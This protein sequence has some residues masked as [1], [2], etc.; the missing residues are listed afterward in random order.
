MIEIP[1]VDGEVKGRQ[2]D[3]VNRGRRRRVQERRG[4]RAG[5]A[6]VVEAVAGMDRPRVRHDASRRSDQIPQLLQQNQEA[7]KADLDISG[8]HRP[9]V[10]RRHKVHIRE[11]VGFAGVG[12]GYGTEDAESAKG[13][14]GGVV[15]IQH[16]EVAVGTVDEP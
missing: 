1:A 12:A 5:E 2:E 8:D 16:E 7:A 13:I 10:P 9:E 3:V 15:H 6:D 14:R 4:L 11:V